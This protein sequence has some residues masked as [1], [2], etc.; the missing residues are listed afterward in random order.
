[1]LWASGAR[2]PA[3]KASSAGDEVICR[4]GRKKTVQV[5]GNRELPDAG[6]GV[7]TEVGSGD[8][9]LTDPLSREGVTGIR[10]TENW[11]CMQERR[12]TERGNCKRG[13]RRGRL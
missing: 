9:G 2:G 10:R 13:E 6:E 7:K 12:G 5:L 8:K 3:G 1:M 4:R 11:G